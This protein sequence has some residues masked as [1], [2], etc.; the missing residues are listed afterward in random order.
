MPPCLSLK[1]R[2]G[3]EALAGHRISGPVGR[4]IG[5]AVSEP[6]LEQDG[7]LGPDAARARN[8]RSVSAARCAGCGGIGK[9]LESSGIRGFRRCT[10][11][12]NAT[13]PGVL[14]VSPL[15]IRGLAA[16]VQGRASQ[17]GNTRALFVASALS[18]RLTLWFYCGKRAARRHGFVGEP[19][20][21]SCFAGCG[22]VVRR[23]IAVCGVRRP[24]ADAPQKAAGA[25]SGRGARA[26]RSPPTPG[27]PATPSRPASFSISTS[28]S[29][30]A[31]SR[32]PIPIGWSS[33]CRRSISSLPAGVGHRRARAD[34]GVP[35]RP[36]D[37][38]RL[39]D[40]V[41]PDR[42]GQDRQVLRAG[43]RQRPAAA[44]GARARGRSTAPPSCSRSAPKAGP[45]C[46]PRSA[47]PTPP[48]APSRRADG[49]ARRAGG[50]APGGRDRSR[51]WRH[52]QR[53]PGRAAAS[54][55]RRWCW[56]FALALRDRIE[57]ARQI[58]RRHDPHRRHLHSA[59][60]PGEDRAQ[61]V[62][63]AVRLDPCRRAAAR[64]GRRPGRHH[65]HA[66]R[67][68]LRRRGRAAGGSR[69]QGRRH[70]RRQSDRGADRGRRHPDRS[71]AARNQD[72]LQP[73][74]PPS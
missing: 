19:R 28:R 47:R 66:V 25:E 23:S 33:T 71:G 17:R 21:S 29:S 48:S 55:K 32:W 3:A 12:L 65:L 57:K 61:P 67:Q 59:R 5:Y 7:N 44:A 27:W 36:G 53:H 69:K 11:R 70:R 56:D 10:G 42:S 6:S 73:L 35:L 43:G 34:Q 15:Y 45:S 18:S 38:G 37:A 50:S 20:K 68:G 31:P 30:C 8:R 1:A 16:R 39:A 60:R 63:G 64:R 72:L 4:I 74:R 51:P 62:G 24:S 54:R 49:Q 26:F 2:R 41:R 22:A 46:G 58:S 14:A 13:Q 9:T 52:R 40:R